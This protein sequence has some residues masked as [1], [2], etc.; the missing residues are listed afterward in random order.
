MPR[1]FLVRRYKQQHARVLME[2]ERRYMKE[3][4]ENTEFYPCLKLDVNTTQRR[5][6]P[7][8]QVTASVP[9]TDVAFEPA[10]KAPPRR[11]RSRGRPRLPRFSRFSLPLSETLLPAPKLV[12][13]RRK[14]KKRQKLT[15]DQKPTRI[16]TRKS[17]SIYRRSSHTENE[18]E[19]ASPTPEEEVGKE[20]E[21]IQPV[22]QEINNNDKPLCET[23]DDV[24]EGNSMENEARQEDLSDKSGHETDTADNEVEDEPT[25]EKTETSK[26]EPPR[27]APECREKKSEPPREQNRNTSRTSGSSKAKEHKCGRS[28]A[29][30]AHKCPECGKQYSTSSN[31]ARHRQ[32]HRSVTDKKAKQ[33]PHCDKIYVSM[34]ALSM[35]IRTHKL[36]CKCHI[37]GKCFSRPWLLQGH[38][39]THTG[40]KPFNCPLCYKS[41]ADKSNLRAHVQTH[42]NVKPYVCKRCNKAFALKSY[43][44]KHEESSCNRDAA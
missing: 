38:I 41:F 21:E 31:L 24:A 32:T 2:E 44:Y 4:E 26:P 18:S 13:R 6:K 29:P 28:P 7:E 10:N 23:T 43:L 17:T 15:S 22:E 5:E 33:C 3:N 12:K 42:S 25:Q 37:C 14:Q 34:P 11:K 36:G 8:L 40:E 27:S 16:G 35:H 30:H 19:M 9:I 39:R 1:S 20:E